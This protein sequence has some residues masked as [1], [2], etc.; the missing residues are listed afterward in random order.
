M[1]K[2]DTVGLTQPGSLQ[3]TSEIVT[4][5]NNSI[6]TT[7]PRALNRLIYTYSINISMWHV[8]RADFLPTRIVTHVF[9]RVGNQLPTL[10]LVS[11]RRF[12]MIALPNCH[13]RESGNP[14]SPM[15]WIPHQSLP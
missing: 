10:R 12:L 7:G 9:D 4:Q 8:G 15:Y 6:V 3:E 13:S 2:Y 1:S 5:L 11:F 14:E